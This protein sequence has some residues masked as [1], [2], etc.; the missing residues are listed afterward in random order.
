LAGADSAENNPTAPHIIIRPVLCDLSRQ[1]GR[2]RLCGP[3][4]G[5]RLKP[6]SRLQRIYGCQE[7]VEEY[8]CNYEL[9]P[10]YES[11]LAS[12][13]L[14]VVARSHN[15]EARAV[16]LANHRFFVATLFQTQMSSSAERPHPL[17]T[18]LL[19]AAADQQQQR[20]ASRQ[21]AGA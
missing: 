5:I 14:E 4:P 1:S 3:I 20:P 12:A 19:Q 6:G 15:G 21:W 16:E 9:N 10:A 18:A 11:Q 13:G 8:F 7:V 2:P 17:L